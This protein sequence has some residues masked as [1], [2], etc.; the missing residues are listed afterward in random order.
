MVRIDIGGGLLTVEV[1]GLDRLVAMRRR[2]EI[3]LSHVVWVQT[4]PDEAYN[5]PTGSPTHALV[6]WMG[7]TGIYRGTDG[8]VFWDVRDP[9]RSIAIGLR[10]EPLIGLVVEV[11]DPD[12]VERAIVSALRGESDRGF[13]R[14]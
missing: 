7:R 10:D 9:G 11:H 13:R 4:R 8:D 1:E 6:P 14:E 2:F 3:P 5:G 12:R